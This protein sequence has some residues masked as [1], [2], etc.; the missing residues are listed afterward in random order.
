[1]TRTNFILAISFLLIWACNTAVPGTGQAW[2]LVHTQGRVRFVFIDPA[3]DWDRRQYDHAIQKICATDNVCQI[4]F[5]SDTSKIPGGLPMNDDQLNAR[6][7]EYKFN[8]NT[9]YRE[10]N[11]PPK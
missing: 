2:R 1:V 4:H 8:A 5:W 9:N 3:Q 6:V 10:F 11:F 7:A